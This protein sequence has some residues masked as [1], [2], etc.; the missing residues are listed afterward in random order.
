[1]GRRQVAPAVS[2]SVGIPL[3]FAATHAILY[4]VSQLFHLP[5]VI[6]RGNMALRS[7]A[8]DGWT[9]NDDPSLLLVM[10]LLPSEEQ[11]L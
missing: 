2:M 5:D 6:D 7:D 10:K 4:T 3:W 11:K 8:A 9:G 1:M